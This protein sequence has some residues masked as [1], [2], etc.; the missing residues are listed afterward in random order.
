MKSQLK[1]IFPQND[2]ILVDGLILGWIRKPGLKDL[3]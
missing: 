1:R 2:R 3:L